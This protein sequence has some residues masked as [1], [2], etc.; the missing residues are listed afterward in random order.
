MHQLSLCFFASRSIFFYERVIR[1]MQGLFGIHVWWIQT[2]HTSHHGWKHTFAGC[3]KTLIWALWALAIS[4]FLFIILLHLLQG[5][6]LDLFVHTV[7]P[8]LWRFVVW[9]LVP[10]DSRLNSFVGSLLDIIRQKLSVVIVIDK[11][12]EITNIGRWFSESVFFLSKFFWNVC[13]FWGLPL[14]H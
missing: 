8:K 13:L 12:L 14:A 6:F 11:P 4:I 9:V 5:P 3:A 10:L 1:Y 7:R 2:R